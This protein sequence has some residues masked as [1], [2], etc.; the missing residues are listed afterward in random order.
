MMG[1]WLRV[2]PHVHSKGI[3]QCSS[4]T[5]E[6]IVDEK[7]KL[8]YDG[9]VLTNHCQPT[10]YPPEKHSDFIERT[11][12]EFNQG[13]EYAD[14]KGFRFY[15]GIEVSVA[16]KEPNYADFLL[17]GV[18]ENFL[19]SSPCL[20][21]LSQKEL[22]EYC[23]QWGV[24]MIQ[25]HPYRQAPRELE[26]M[27]GIELNCSKKDLDKKPLVDK[28]AREHGLLVT[29]GMDYHFVENTF[30]GGMYIPE[31]CKT[32]EDIAKWIRKDRRIK[33]F[34]GEEEKIYESKNIFL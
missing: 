30:F 32:A 17:Y 29:C 5:C 27:H 20:Y 1:K 21:T 18:T 26:Y 16:W 12:E 7:M 10:Y 9:V 34:V 28:Y 19:R 11:I 15:L 24:V 22:F 25:A 8:G 13:K 4:V 23:N 3:S 31:S 14:K 6:Q 2:D 33:V